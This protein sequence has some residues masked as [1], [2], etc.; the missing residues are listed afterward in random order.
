MKNINVLGNFSGRN[1]G[2]A[3]ILGCLLRDISTVSNDVRFLIP[4]INP[5][6]VR[7]SY[8]QYNIKPVS[9]LPWNLSAKIFGVPVVRATLASDLVLVTDAILFDRKL[10]DPLFNYLWTLSWLLPMAKKRH[11]PVVLYNSSIGPIRTNAGNRCLQKVIASTSAIILRDRESVDLVKKTGV[12]LP[13]VFEGADCALNAKAMDDNRFDQI[14]QKE[15]LFRSQR[16]VIGFN[17][18]TYVDVYVREDGKTFGRKNLVDLY[19]QVVNRIIDSLDTDIIFVETQHMDLGI[20]R[21]TFQKIARPDRVRLISNRDYNYEDI[22]AVL[23][24]MDLFVGMRTHSLILS[25]A[26]GVPPVGIVTYPKNRGF[27][28]TIG[29]EDHL[30]EFADLTPDK[31]SQII[32]R[33][34]GNRQFTR[35]RMQP[36]VEKEKDKASQ[37]AALLRRL[38]LL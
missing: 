36:Q 32:T 17:I 12:P 25:A 6:F 16:P 1:A 23:K 30:I 34:F 3:A 13:E 2:D 29:M 21:E 10:Y 5:P 27:M 9:L 35:A 15:D 37:G 22:C 28:R 14:K 19:A 38:D 31:F 18:N 7:R 11:I 33:A 4:T 26:M 8:N 24:R 20:A